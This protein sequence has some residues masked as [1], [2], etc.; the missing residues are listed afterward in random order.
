MDYILRMLIVVG[1]A[2]GKNTLKTICA[3]MI[4][5]SFLLAA[6]VGSTGAPK[7]LSNL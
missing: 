2:I 6:F 4:G 3:K 5:K 1:Q 7:S